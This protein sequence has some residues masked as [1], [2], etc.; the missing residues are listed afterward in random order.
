MPRYFFHVIDGEEIIDGEGTMLAGVNEARAE[1]I[2]V[3][4]EMLKDLGGKFWN[5]GQWQIRVTDEA[6]DKVCALTFSADQ[7]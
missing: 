5:N 3:S 2:V 1:A 4:G 7:S 6:G